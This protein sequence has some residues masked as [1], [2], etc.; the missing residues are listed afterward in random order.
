MV[1][2]MGSMDF[3]DG[4]QQLM[5]ML[6]RSE[7]S[8]QVASA[9]D[10]LYDLAR[11]RIH[12]LGPVLVSDPRLGRKERAWEL[13]RLLLKAI[14]E[15][16]P[17]PK[18]AV[19]SPEWRRYRLMV[20]RYVR[21]LDP[22]ATAEQLVISRRHYYR[23]HNAAVEL[24]ATILWRRCVEQRP[25]DRQPA[26]GS[27]EQESLNR[28]QLLRLETARMTQVDPWAPVGKVLEGVLSLLQDRLHRRGIDVSLQLDEALPDAA[29]GR[30]LLRQILLG[31]LGYLVEHAEQATIR[32]AVQAEGEV[33]DVSLAVEPPGAVRPPAQ[34]GLSTDLPVLDLAALS[35]AQIE[36]IVSGHATVGF[37]LRL[38]AS[39]QHTVLVIDDNEDVLQLFQRYLHRHHYHVVTAQT[40]SDGLRLASELRPLAV[41]LDLMM[42]GR[43]GWDVLQSLQN[44]PDTR[45]IPIVVC[46]VLAEKELALSLGATAFLEKPITE[47]TL[48]SLLETLRSH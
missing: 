28:L 37:E 6:S 30:N 38:P 25:R 48:V 47:D 34:T 42:P 11:L 22:K 46:S 21:G 9:Y 39:P 24:I 40:A 29:M 31:T 2:M 15:L 3:A 19:A 23:E 4:A 35:G 16:D 14:E 43:D 13:H 18:A 5:N 17:G 20:L 36:P 44:Q 33:V 7:F 26:E 41:T 10:R 27:G 1:S 12:P 32:L 45:D 8:K